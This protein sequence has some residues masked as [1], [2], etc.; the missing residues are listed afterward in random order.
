MIELLSSAPIIVESQSFGYINT[1]KYHL[2]FLMGPRWTS[3]GL[4]EVSQGDLG[5]WMAGLMGGLMLAKSER[6]TARIHETLPNRLIHSKTHFGGGLQPSQ[7]MCVHSV[8]TCFLVMDWSFH[9]WR[10]R[11][12]PLFHM[13]PFWIRWFLGPSHQGLCLVENAQGM[14][15]FQAFRMAEVFALGIRHIFHWS[16]F[17]GVICHRIK[18]GFN[19]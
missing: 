14:W 15:C 16:F 13:N 1:Y 10:A 2:F 4:F 19:I 12:C 8:Y 7:R 6:T 11:V 9:Q 5:G 18:A 3:K 17:T